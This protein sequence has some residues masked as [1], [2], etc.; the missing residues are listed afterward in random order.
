MIYPHANQ[1]LISTHDV[2]GSDCNVESRIVWIRHVRTVDCKKVKL[3]RYSPGQALGVPGGWGSRIS[4][5][6]AHEAGKV[7]SPTHLHEGFLVLISFRGWVDPRATMW[8]E[9]LSQWNIPVTPPGIEPATCPDK[10]VWN[11]PR[12]QPLPQTCRRTEEADITMLVSASDLAATSSAKSG[13]AITVA[14]VN[15]R[16]AVRIST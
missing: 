13:A 16:A 5:Q 4:R 2:W 9:G 8:P 1:S 10:L 7:V 14:Y 12:T 15:P 3:S 6:S 11:E